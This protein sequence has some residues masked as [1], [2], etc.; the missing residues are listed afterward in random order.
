LTT[1]HN[2]TKTRPNK[3]RNETADFAPRGRGNKKAVGG[4]ALVKKNIISP[5]KSSIALELVL[6]IRAS[7]GIWVGRRVVSC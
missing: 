6:R 5:R 2:R 4:V 7:R 3:A 1:L